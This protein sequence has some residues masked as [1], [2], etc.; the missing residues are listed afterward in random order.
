MSAAIPEPF[1]WSETYDI[2][3]DLLNEQHKVLFTMIV[4]LDANQAD[5]SKLTALLEYVQMHF[6][7]EED[8]FA[9]KKY[10]DANS[11]KEVHDKFVADAVAATKDGVNADII[12]FLKQW[13]VN[14]IMNSDMAYVGKL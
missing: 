6:K 13:L 12:A 10:A 14:H 4:D 5:A 1:A 8:L 2:K 11:H 7:T 9:E 3:H